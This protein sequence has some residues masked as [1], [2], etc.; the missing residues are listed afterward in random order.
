MPTTYYTQHKPCYLSFNE[1]LCLVILTQKAKRMLQSVATSLLIISFYP[2][3]QNTPLFILCDF[4]DTSAYLFKSYTIC[5]VF[6]RIRN[7]TAPILL[8]HDKSDVIVPFELGHKV[9][10]LAINVILGINYL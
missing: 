9:N 6:C 5:F 10:S 3:N 1:S 2:T 8:L 4:C 7:V